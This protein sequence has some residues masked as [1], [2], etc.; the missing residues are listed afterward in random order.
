MPKLVIYDSGKYV[1]CQYLVDLRYI[2]NITPPEFVN[3]IDI[4]YSSQSFLNLVPAANVTLCFFAGLSC[5]QI[6]HDH[7]LRTFFAIMPCS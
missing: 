5:P 4:L 7:T 3:K 2:Y 1:N 6:L